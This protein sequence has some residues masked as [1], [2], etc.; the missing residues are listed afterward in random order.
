MQLDQQ[1]RSGSR[2][3]T[4]QSV[5]KFAGTG[6]GIPAAGRV[7]SKKVSRVQPCSH[8]VPWLRVSSV[9]C[10]NCI[11]L[12]SMYFSC[13]ARDLFRLFLL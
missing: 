4:G 11:V 6:L 9:V 2:R 12:S 10:V 3:V 13:S 5:G 1:N 7:G 8:L